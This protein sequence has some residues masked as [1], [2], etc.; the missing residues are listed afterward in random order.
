MSYHVVNSHNSWSK[1]EEV[2]LGDVYPAS[3][4]DH[5]ESEVRDCFYEIT[6]KTQQDLKIIENKLKEFGV[7]VCRPSYKCIEDFLQHDQTL[8]KPEITPRDYYLV[9]GQKIYAKRSWTRLNPWQ[10]HLDRY[11]EQNPGCVQNV[12][13]TNKLGITGASTVRVGVDLFIDLGPKD[14][15]IK[16]AIVEIYNKNFQKLFTDYRVNLLFNGGHMDGCFAV[17]QP[18]LILASSHYDGYDKTFPDW[19]IINCGHPEFHNHRERSGPWHNGTW[20]LPGMKY[21]HAF[22]EHVIKHAQTWVGNYTET[23]FEVNCLVIDENNV[24]VLG[25]N[26]AIQRRLE[27]HGITTHNVPFRTRTF[28]DGGMHCLTLDIRRQSKIENF[29]PDRN[30]TEIIIYD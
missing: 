23:F 13:H 24:M 2:W 26:E 28:W 4:Y 22:N 29:F 21:S 3:W 8:K 1:L 20:W 16:K 5:L 14:P 27:S 17:L 18:D 15:D 30:N 10:A 9:A 7:T 25:E 6:E 11:D 12:L 19:K